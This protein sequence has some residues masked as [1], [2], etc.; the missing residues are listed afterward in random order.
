MAIDWSPLDKFVLSKVRETRMPSVVVG[1]V[2]RRGEILYGRSFGFRDVERGLP[3]T[4]RTNYGIGSITKS[5]TALSVVKMS[6]EGLIDLRDP[7]SKYVP[8]LDVKPFGEEIRVEHLLTHSTGLPALGYAE[9]FIRGT[10]GLSSA[11]LPISKPEDLLAFMRGSSEWSVG[12]PGEKFYYLNEGYVL[13]GLIISRVAKRSYEEHVKETILKPLKMDKT[14]FSEEEFSRD[15]EAAAPYIL[16]RSG[17]LVKSKFPFGVNADGGLISNAVDMSK[18]LAMLLNRGVYGELEV[19]PRA[20]VEAVEEKRIEYPLKLFGDESYGY[21]WVVT[22]NFYGQ[23]LVY[24]GGSV[25]VH[26]AYAGYLPSSGYGV[27]V[28]ANSS[29][30][31]LSLI[32]MYALSLALGQDPERTLKPIAYE[33][34]LSKLTG[35][36][37]TYSGTL[38]LSVER[39]GDFL[40]IVYKDK[41]HESRTPIVPV[42]VREDYAEFYTLASTRKIPVYFYVERDRVVMIYERYK[43]VKRAS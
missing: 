30:Y 6:F 5:F 34:A 32:G 12:R 37:E 1:V 40:E 14:Y 21:G 15:A 17:S 42:E 3:A 19:V 28:L 24:H 26:T 10:L 41:Y 2:N 11:W 27:V 22:E 39:N 7:V 43:L 36:Y 4:L 9:A 23:K 33:N 20:V 8:E 29:G 18:Y 38:Q 31:P 35:T 16:D 25:L 13:L